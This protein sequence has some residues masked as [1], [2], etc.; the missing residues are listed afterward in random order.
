MMG[1]EKGVCL[2]VSLLVC[3]E[4]MFWGG[5]D[6]SDVTRGNEVSRGN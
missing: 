6:G 5:R 4:E 1:D 3:G 2:M